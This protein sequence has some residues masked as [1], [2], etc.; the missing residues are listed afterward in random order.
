MKLRERQDSIALA[1]LKTL[2]ALLDPTVAAQTPPLTQARLGKVRG[3]LRQLGYKIE[4]PPRLTLDE[5]I[6]QEAKRQLAGGGKASSAAITS[7][8]ADWILKNWNEQQPAV[9][10]VRRATKVQNPHDAQVY[11]HLQAEVQKYLGDF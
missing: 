9:S 8:V 4:P 10:E 2:E 5:L 3:E 6:K 11:D 1:L 7:S